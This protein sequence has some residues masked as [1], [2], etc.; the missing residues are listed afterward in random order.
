[1]RQTVVLKFVRLL[2]ILCAAL[3][4]GIAFCHSLELPNKLTLPA[5][6]WLTVQQ[7]LYRGFGA[8]AGPIEVAAIVLTLALLPLVRKRRMTLLWTLIAAICFVAGLV[9]WFQVVNP[10]NLLVDSWTISTLPATWVQARN[11]WEYGHAMHATL[12]IT[13]LVALV[14]SVL[15]DTTTGASHRTN[16]Y[17][18]YD[19]TRSV[20]PHL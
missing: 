6:T 13:G 2:S 7:V 12:F 18:P 9:V 16:T 10:V 3:I 5:D 1:M 20:E 11:Q 14:L 8:K 19:K 17:P 4:G 15:A